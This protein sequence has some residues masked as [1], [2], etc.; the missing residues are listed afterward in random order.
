M[1]LM[2]G[3]EKKCGMRS[4]AKRS[5][6]V[7]MGTRGFF[8]RASGNFVSSISRRL[9]ACR[10]GHFLRL[11]RNRKPRMKSLWQPE[12]G[13]V[14]SSPPLPE[15]DACHVHFVFHNGTV[16]GVM[17]CNYS[18]CIGSWLF[19]LV[20]TVEILRLIRNLLG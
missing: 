8:S 2:N 3:D 12:Y 7:T 10:A 1:G 5:G 20:T 4:F 16:Y 13:N 18:S 6:N 14:G 17:Y 15:P 9:F 11:D 19:K